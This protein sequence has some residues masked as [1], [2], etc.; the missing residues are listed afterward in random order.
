MTTTQIKNTEEMHVEDAIALAQQIDRTKQALKLLEDKLK[1]YV[2]LNGPVNANGKV[3]DY[4]HSSTWNFAPDRL[5]ALCGMLAIDGF[6]P[7]ELLNLSATA[8]KKTGYSDD[9]LSQYGEKKQ[10]NKS[11]RSV[12][13]ENYNK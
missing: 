13:A 12:K 2:E 9:L 1:A 3:W 8:L 7:F 10:G 5:K 4:F 6:N 11:F